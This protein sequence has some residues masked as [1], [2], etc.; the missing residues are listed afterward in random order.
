MDCLQNHIVG[1]KWQKYIAYNSFA[2]RVKLSYG[3]IFDEI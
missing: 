1:K 2:T 3:P